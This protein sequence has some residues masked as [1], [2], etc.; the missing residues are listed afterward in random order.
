MFPVFVSEEPDA[1]ES[2][3]LSL[4]TS[5]PARAHVPV[6]YHHGEYVYIQLIL[7]VMVYFVAIVI[8]L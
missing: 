2:V 8:T 5:L 4:D 7:I 1:M 3:D 6:F